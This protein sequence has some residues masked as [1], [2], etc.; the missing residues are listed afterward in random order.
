METPK[1]IL[2]SPLGS[3]DPVRFGWDGACLHILRHF[4]PDMVVLFYT[5][6][7]EDTEKED[8]R[9]TRAIKRLKPE[10]PIK[11]IFTGITDPH[12][13]DNFIRILPDAVH[14][15]HN[16]YPDAKI[17]LNLSSGTP[18]IKTVMAILSMEGD[19]CEGIQVESPA[20][21]SNSGNPAEKK[22]VDVDKMLSNNC[23]NEPDAPE[24]W[25]KPPL[26][27][28][29]YYEDRNSINSLVDRYDYRGAQEVAKKNSDI[30]PIVTQLLQHAS[31]RAIVMTNEAR[32]ILSKYN[33]ISL[34][35]FQGTQ[36]KLVE[37]FLTMQMDRKTG[38][39]S[40]LT[41]KIVPFLYELLTEYIKKN[42]KLS[43]DDLCEY[44]NG[45]PRLTREKTARRSPELL[46]YLDSLFKENQ[47]YRSGELSYKILSNLCDF[48][49][50]D[51]GKNECINIELNQ[52]MTNC[53]GGI[54]RVRYLRN[55]IAH[56]IA[57]VDAQKFEDVVGCSPEELINTLFK[58]LLL[59][60]EEQSD[61]I[62]KQRSIYDTINGWIA[63]AM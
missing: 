17:L 10:C 55:D 52:Q 14:Q 5:K 22:D 45:V 8:H 38:S 32:K 26:R 62:K 37:Y 3:T 36:E 7:M 58:M 60:Y 57:N 47:K 59:V 23:D 27:I 35:P 16:E 21:R 24:R 9:Y 15:V 29:H 44:V 61:V 63:D 28:L 48:M 30:P 6:E 18:Q 4:N 50:T 54:C 41:M 46:A 39:L 25:L 43:L 51:E 42:S 13:Y 11:E 56:I 34:L 2:F 19:W 33:G 20:G 1:S 12:I 40:N 53:L 49:L 31:Q